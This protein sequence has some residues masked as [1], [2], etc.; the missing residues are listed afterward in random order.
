M[1]I[2]KPV[3]Y[4][5]ITVAALMLLILFSCSPQRSDYLSRVSALEEGDTASAKEEEID[6]LEKDIKSLEK[7]VEEMA[8]G[9]QKLGTY[10]RMLAV[11]FFDAGMFGPASDYIQKAIRIYPENHVLYYY[12]AIC[13]AKLS[14]TLAEAD[15]RKKALLDAEFFYRQA[16]QLKPA[17]R[18]A[19]YGLSV[20]YVF[21]LSSPE[22]AVPLLE[23]LT[24]MDEK[25]TDA[26]FLLG[27]AYAALGEIE[28]ALET[29]RSIVNIDEESAAAETARGLITQLGG[30]QG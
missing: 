9:T 29:Y 30:D 16:L 17:Y 23:G 5:L 4:E 26:R 21:E 27:R 12:Q 25:N 19:L 22:R 14:R 28:E 24:S 8:K 3:R 11:D 1:L 10:Y 6:A 15:S 18:D 20:L 2:S 7:S 13:T